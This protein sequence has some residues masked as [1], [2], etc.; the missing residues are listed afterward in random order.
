MKTKI[1]SR[2]NTLILC[3][4]ISTDGWIT[5]TEKSQDVCILSSSDKG[6]L[7]K[8]KVYFDK[9]EISTA[10]NKGRG[11]IVLNGSVC[12]PM[13]AL[14]LHRRY[15]KSSGKTMQRQVLRDSIEYWKLH[16]FIRTDKYEKLCKLTQGKNNIQLNERGLE[17]WI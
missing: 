5:A 13:Y 1:W 17:K 3:V 7:E 2:E 15:P 6:W 11:Q 16:D 10:V 14:R 9:E 4:F 8:L 12:D